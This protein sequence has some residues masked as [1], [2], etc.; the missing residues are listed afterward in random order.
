MKQGHIEDKMYLYKSW[1][2]KAEK[3]GTNSFSDWKFPDVSWFKL[4]Q[5]GFK[6]E[7]VGA[8]QRA[9][10]HSYIGY[11]PGLVSMLS[12]PISHSHQLG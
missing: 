3:I 11:L 7:M 8:Q 6:M 10:A 5:V 12:V 4:H 9:L 2:G 1:K